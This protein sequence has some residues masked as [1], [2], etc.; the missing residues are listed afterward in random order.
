MI[1]ADF[2]SEIIASDEYLPYSKV[3]DMGD[4]DILEHEG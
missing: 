1:K 4:Q 2:L 3:N